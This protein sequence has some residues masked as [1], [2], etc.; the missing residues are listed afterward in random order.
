M[1]ARERG[2]T[3]FVVPDDKP[4]AE[5]LSHE[6]SVYPPVPLRSIRRLRRG[7]LWSVAE[8]LAASQLL[9]GF[10]ER[11]DRFKPA[12]VCTVMMPDWFATAAALYARSRRLPLVLF[13]HDDYSSLIPKSAVDHLAALYRQASIRLCVSA[14]MRDEYI[15]LFGVS[16]D[17]LPPI[18]GHRVRSVQEQREGQPIVVGF[19]GSIGF[20]YLDAIVALADHLREFDGRL[21]IASPTP[22]K[23]IRPVCEHPSVQDLGVLSPDAVEPSFSAAGVNVLAV[24][25]SFDPAEQRAFRL[26]FPSKLTEYVTFGL[27]VLILAPSG[28]SASLWLRDKP[29]I[30]VLVNELT[31]A[32]LLP[33]LR[34]LSKADGRWK[35]AQEIRS[36]ASEF[37]PGK[38]NRQFECSLTEAARTNR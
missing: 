11:A 10:S 25:Q 13:C 27:P 1:Q 28:A 9:R 7:F 31:P 37:D 12:V 2:T 38:L 34:R 21:V 15:R 23:L 8:R 6:V 17:V 14:V 32:A 36:A 20:G 3:M 18:P 24:I 19:A 29:E 22:R 30:A 33:A 35:L 4:I 26:N 16:G 5:E